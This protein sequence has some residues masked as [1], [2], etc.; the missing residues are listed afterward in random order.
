MAT[1]HFDDLAANLPDS[2]KKGPESNNHKL[3]LV[4]KH[5]YDKIR[6]ML[7]S[8]FAV[9]DLDN[10]S[11]ATLDLYGTRLQ[12]ERGTLSDERYRLRL[13]GKVAQSLSDGTRESVVS[14]L[15]YILQCDASQIQIRGTE[16]TGKAELLGAPLGKLFEAGFT[17]DEITGLINELL[18][19][20]VTLAS[21]NYYGTFQFGE[22]EAE[23]DKA[24]GFSDDTGT[25]GG[26]FGLYGLQ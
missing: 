22:L 12:L 9:T 19:V 21:V 25:I 5:I 17:T 6:N 23:A 24:R 3:L 26:Y 1:F 13:K 11:G 4:E 14:T 15:A 8:V 2:F 20:N 16:T 7:E 10:A 18:P